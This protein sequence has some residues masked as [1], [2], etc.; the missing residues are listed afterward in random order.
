[1]KCVICTLFEG[2]YHLGVAV[3]VNSLCQA[4]FRGTIYAG[5]RGPLPPWTQGKA[6]AMPGGHWDMQIT[7]DVRLVFI[8][9]DTPAHFTNFKPDFLLQV[10]ALASPESEAVAY[11]DPDIVINTD[12][13][14][15]EDWLSCGVALCEDVNSPIH[16][17]DPRRI[18]WRRFFKP[19][20]FDLHFRTA[21]YINGGFVGLSWAHRKFLVT[22]QE[23]ITAIA[24]HLGGKDVVGISGGRRLS[25]A[26]GFADCFHQCDQD[27]LNATLEACPEI[28]ISVLGQQAMAF[29]AGRCILPHALGPAKPWRRRY[30]REA[31]SGSPPALVDK[32]FWKQVD[33]PI[34]P[35][36]R[37]HVASTRFRLALS[38]ALGRLI[39]RT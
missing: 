16:E 26:Y 23:F 34:R 39:Q 8:P 37:V 11:L 2:E 33:G 4:G 19:L 30:L 1:M 25:G 13:S 38:A 35:F 27:A 21:S 32:V 24:A 29:H 28:P 15:L 5:F 7:P 12:W 6:N 18:G 36:S 17:N 31:L 10:E 9:L 14:Y 22:W 3:L 20:G